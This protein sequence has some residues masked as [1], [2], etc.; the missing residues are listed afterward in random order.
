MGRRTVLW[1][2][3]LLFLVG[4]V[5]RLEAPLTM[6][7]ELSAHAQEEQAAAPKKPRTEQT[8]TGLQSGPPSP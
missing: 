1:V 3:T 4:S 6:V 7:A 2:L 5:F 8:A